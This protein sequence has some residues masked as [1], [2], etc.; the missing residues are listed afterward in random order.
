MAAGGACAQALFGRCRGN[1][2]PGGGDGAEAAAAALLP[3]GCG[4]GACGALLWGGGRSCERGVVCARGEGRLPAGCSL[5]AG[6]ERVAHVRPWNRGCG[7]CGCR[8]CPGFPGAS[9]PWPHAE[10]CRS[11]SKLSF[12]PGSGGA[13]ELCERLLHSRKR[14]V[15]PPAGARGARRVLQAAG[16]ASCFPTA[17]ESELQPVPSVRLAWK[18]RWWN[19]AK[20]TQPNS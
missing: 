4:T 12:S 15:V 2:A 20:N 6:P 8:G 17:R 1:G 7:C 18:E 10:R 11:S 14:R 9:Q 5:S 3:A 19:N 13:A 16:S